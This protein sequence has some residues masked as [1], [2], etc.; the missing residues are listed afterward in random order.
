MEA[1]NLCLRVSDKADRRT[2]QNPHTG[3]VLL[4]VKSEGSG[5]RLMLFEPKEIKDLRS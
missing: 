3:L 4:E 1:K 5:V 2:V